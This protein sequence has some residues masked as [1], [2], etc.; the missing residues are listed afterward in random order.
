MISRLLLGL[1]LGGVLIF[2]ACGPQPS[3]KSADISTK[4]SKTSHVSQRIITCTDEKIASGIPDTVRFGRLHSGEIALLQLQL[5][6]QT[7]RPVVITSYNRSCGCTTLE[8][9]SQPVMPNEAAPLTLYFNSRGEW[10]WQLKTL[11]ILLAGYSKPLRLFI[12]AEVE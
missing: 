9:D 11:D 1:L 10:G 4:M 5:A 3:Q 12:E 7:P 2:V 8:Y 6:N